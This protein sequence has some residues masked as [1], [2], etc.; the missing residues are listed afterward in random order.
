MLL[1]KFIKTVGIVGIR[2]RKSK[3]QISRELSGTYSSLCK[4]SKAC[5]RR[6]NFTSIQAAFNT[7][8]QKLSSIMLRRK[9]SPSASSNAS[10][11]HILPKY[12]ALVAASGSVSCCSSLHESSQLSEYC[13]IHATSASHSN[14]SKTA[15]FDP[16]P[17]ANVTAERGGGGGVI[18]SCTKG[19]LHIIKK[20]KKLAVQFIESESF[21]IVSM[22]LRLKVRPSMPVTLGCRA[23]I[24][25]NT[26]HK[27]ARTMSLFTAAIRRS[28]KIG[29]SWLVSWGLQTMR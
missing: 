4:N 27:M 28:T 22:N 20:G 21:T 12:G 8:S 5:L 26:C 6:G 25:G 9:N 13:L 16:P 19:Y 11:R 18:C 15:L 24:T 29:A 1:R 10:L 17:N 23:S 2:R 3:F 7:A 14:G